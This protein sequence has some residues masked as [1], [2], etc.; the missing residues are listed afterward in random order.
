MVRRIDQH[1]LTGFFTGSEIIDYA[2]KDDPE[3]MQRPFFSLSKRKRNKAIEYTSPDGSIWVRVEANPLHG[4]ATIWDADILIWCI[5]RLMARRQAGEND[6]DGA[7]HTTP[8]ELL[9]GIAR[10]TGGED[11]RRLMAALTRLMTTRVE[12]NI[13][14]GKRRFAS[15]HYLDGVEG[16]SDDP[17][18]DELKSISI[19]VP[20]WLL[21]GIMNGSV[22]TLDREYFT[23]KGG[24]ERAL[25]RAARK[26]AGSQAQGWTCRMSVLHEKTGSEAAVK[27][28]AFKVRDLCQR[29]ELPR[30]AM[31]ETKT[32]GGEAAVHFVD[33]NFIAAAEAQERRLATIRAGRDPARMA[34][35]DGGHNPRQFETAYAEWC[36]MNH[37]ADFVQSLRH[38]PRLL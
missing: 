16:A 18:S 19:R 15:F 7:I 5:S 17:N 35:I 2:P 32:D 6:I 20:D 24:I 27:M 31:T 9:T 29:D 12:T 33:R 13:R 37:P 28:F 1:P 8:Y 22:L 3:M 23:M 10:D 21:H 14:A 11:Y 34:W 26:H 38:T 4:M 25:Y 36:D 30:Y